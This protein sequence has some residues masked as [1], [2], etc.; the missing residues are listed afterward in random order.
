MP[1]IDVTCGETCEAEL[2]TDAIE[3]ASRQFNTCDIFFL[4][5]VSSQLAFF[6]NKCHINGI[7]L[8]EFP[9][10]GLHLDFCHIDPAVSVTTT[11]DPSHHWRVP[12][13]S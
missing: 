10:Y 5:I 1:Q 9:L 3:F 6:F 12:E 2:R 7:T 4:S 8:S 13:A 11:E